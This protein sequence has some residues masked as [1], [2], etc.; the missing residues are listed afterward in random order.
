M[1]LVVT[2]PGGTDQVDS[3]EII[4]NHQK[5]PLGRQSHIQETNTGLFDGIK[6]KKIGMCQTR[7]MCVLPYRREFLTLLALPPISFIKIT[8]SKGP[9]K[10]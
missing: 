3:Q 1:R 10:L 5:G 2:I 4:Q 9:I 7:R 6:K 8:P